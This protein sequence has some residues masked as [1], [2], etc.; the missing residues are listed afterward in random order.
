[1]LRACRNEVDTPLQKVRWFEGNEL[2]YSDFTV[3]SN[4]KAAIQGYDTILDHLPSVLPW[5]VSSSI[6]QRPSSYLGNTGIVGWSN[7]SDNAIHRAGARSR[8]GLQAAASDYASRNCIHEPIGFEPWSPNPPKLDSRYPAPVPHP[9]G[10]TLDQLI[11][12]E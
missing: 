9:T 5:I 10:T 2:F 7:R 11:S 4:A 3:R 8:T 1:V 6:L 12:L